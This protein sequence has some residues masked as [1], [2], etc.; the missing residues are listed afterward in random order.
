MACVLGLVLAAVA[1]FLADRLDGSAEAAAAP[2]VAAVPAETETATPADEA[3]DGQPPAGWYADPANPAQRRYW[4]GS[5]WTD[6][7]H[8]GD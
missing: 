2:S 8:E 4:D 6:H 1:F 7:T 5:A 3:A